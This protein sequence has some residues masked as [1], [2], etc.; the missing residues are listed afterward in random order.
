M[1]SNA[2]LFGILLLDIWAGLEC[3]TKKLHKILRICT[4]HWQLQPIT[5][6][7]FKLLSVFHTWIRSVFFRAQWLI[8]WENFKSSFS[9][10]C[11]VCQ[12]SWPQENHFLGRSLGNSSQR[13]PPWWSTSRKNLALASF[14]FTGCASKTDPKKTTPLAQPQEQFSAGS[15]PLAFLF[16]AG[17]ASRTNPKKTTP[18]AQPQEQF[19]AGYAL[20]TNPG[21][22][23]PLSF[24][25]KTSVN[26]RNLSWQGTRCK[27]LDTPLRIPWIVSLL[28]TQY[29]TPG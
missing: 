20:L 18:L 9:I 12:Q 4:Y 29:P 15:A 22:G 16:H 24:S 8:N 26:A 10:F 13:D 6:L 3:T 19:S 14:Y 11:W 5:L 27:F 25:V 21:M 1:H 7:T 23:M 2:N 17:C 28:R